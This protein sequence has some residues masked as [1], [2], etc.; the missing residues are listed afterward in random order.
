M[1]IERKKKGQNEMKKFLAVFFSVF[2]ALSATTVAFAGAENLTCDSCYEVFGKEEDYKAHVSGGCLVDFEP[3]VYCG[4]S[5]ANANHAAHQLTCPK[6]AGTCEYCGKY[7]YMNQADYE[8]HIGKDL[9]GDKVIGHDDVENN[10]EDCKVTLAIGD[11][12]P[13][14]KIF[15]KIVEALKKVDWKGLLGKVGDLIG[16]ID[17]GGLI[18]KLK[19]ILEK[20]VEFVKGAIA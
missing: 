13:V 10:A 7:D 4:G 18:A 5:I 16:G 15:D 19:P 20:V 14:A 11:K 12:V 8:Y 6:G 17:F 3:C 9:N 1:R 2:F